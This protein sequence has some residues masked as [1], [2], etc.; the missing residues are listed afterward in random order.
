MVQEKGKTVSNP[1]RNIRVM[2]IR[3]QQ[4]HRTAL[5]HATA[6]IYSV[7]PGTVAK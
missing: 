5:V 4:S 6:T 2:T 7:F 1:D 3:P